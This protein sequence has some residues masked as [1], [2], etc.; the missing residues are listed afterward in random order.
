MTTP[1]SASLRNVVFAFAGGAAALLGL[2]LFWLGVAAKPLYTSRIGHLMA[3]EPY[4]PAALLF[5]AMYLFVIV[6]YASLRAS[7]WNDAAR[8]GAGLGAF[9]YATYDL[10]NWAVLREWPVS[11]VVVDIAWGVALTTIVAIAGRIASRL[12]DATKPA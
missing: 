9:A 12:P 11:V 7:S 3:A 2:D 6:R 1:P 5:Y 4:W 8:R 10:T